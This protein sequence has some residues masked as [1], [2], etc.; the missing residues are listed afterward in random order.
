MR[1]RC[2]APVR[3]ADTASRLKVVALYDYGKGRDDGRRWRC[4]SGAFAMESDPS[5][6]DAL[7]ADS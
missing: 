5:S 3:E 1:H 2:V 4:A 6:Y 7:A